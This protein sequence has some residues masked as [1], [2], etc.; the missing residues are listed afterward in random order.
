MRKAKSRSV[1]DSAALDAFQ[2]MILEREAPRSATVPSLR[3]LSLASAADGF[4]LPGMWS[5]LP[6]ELSSFLPSLFSAVQRRTLSI[7]GHAGHTPFLFWAAICS[8]F[9]V[10]VPARYRTYRGLVL[11]DAKELDAL[12][13]ANEQAKEDWAMHLAREEYEEVAA[14]REGKRFSAYVIPCPAFFLTVID[15]QGDETFTD[16]D[17]SKIRPVARMLAVLR[18]D[19]TQVTDVGL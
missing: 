17:V 5:D 12:E 3:E 16:N 14:R 11:D 4:G 13:K 18:L 1:L 2:E 6:Y 15:L 8:K 7:E 10:D 19:R 9:G